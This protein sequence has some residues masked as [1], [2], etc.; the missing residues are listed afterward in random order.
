M[1]ETLLKKDK[2]IEA[3]PSWVFEN[4]PTNEELFMS[5]EYFEMNSDLLHFSQEGGQD[6]YN[7]ILKKPMKESLAR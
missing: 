4:D 6:Y 5:N 3:L 2:F 7:Y 1:I